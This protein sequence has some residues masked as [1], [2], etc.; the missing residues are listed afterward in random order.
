MSGLFSKTSKST[1]DV[2]HLQGNSP[3][4][5]VD[6]TFASRHMTQPIPKS[7]MYV[8]RFSLSHPRSLFV[9]SS[10]S[11]RSHHIL[12]TLSPRSLL[13]TFFLRRPDESIPAKVVYQ[14]IKD[15]RQL[16]SRP[17]LNLASFVTTYME[18][19]A[20]QLMMDSLDINFVDTDEYVSESFTISIACSPPQP[21]IRSLDVLSRSLNLLRFALPSNVGIRPVRRSRTAASAC[22][23]RCSILLRSMPW[24]TVTPWARRLSGV[25][26]QSCSVPFP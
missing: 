26:K 6:S 13:S 23:P 9:L 3:S 15:L 14:V 12:T 20:R 11:L 18:D 2:S 5:F 7:V 10:F 1:K 25:R 21:R 4:D 24:A 16:D 17:V 8:W 22:W 19:E